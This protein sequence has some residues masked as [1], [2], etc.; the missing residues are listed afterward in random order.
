MRRL[1][2][3]SRAGEGLAV[4]GEALPETGSMEKIANRQ[5]NTP[6]S[7]MG[8]PSSPDDNLR[9]ERNP[10]DYRSSSVA[11]S[12]SATIPAASSIRRTRS[13]IPINLSAPMKCSAITRAISVSSMRPPRRLTSP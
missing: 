10:I 6:S 13:L 9:T 1:V 4:M 2:V 5:R 11:H 12:S 8:A 3:G 7:L